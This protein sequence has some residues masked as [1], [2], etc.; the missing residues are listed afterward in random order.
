MNQETPASFPPPRP[1]DDDRHLKGPPLGQGLAHTLTSLFLFLII[2][3]GVALILTAFVIQ[4]YQVDGQSM[5]TTLQDHDRLIVSKIPRTFA[6]LTHHNY[7]PNRGDIIVFNQSG[8][9]DIYYQKQLIKRIIGLPGERVVIKN[10]SITIYNQA[11][12]KGFNPDTQ[13]GYN[14]RAQTTEGDI[15]VTLQ[16]DEVFVCGDNRGNS[17]DSRYFGPINVNTIVGK[18][19]VRI[20]PLNNTEIF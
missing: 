9:P 3:I 18:L 2:P 1:P 10:G 8:L 20:L 14:I 15:D 17:E 11:H 6:R 4:S 12:P 19:V 7:V 16:P 5:E 13:D